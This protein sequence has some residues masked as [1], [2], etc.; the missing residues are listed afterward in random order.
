MAKT[1]TFDEF[2]P[3][4]NGS[5]R[6]TNGAIDCPPHNSY[7]EVEHD[8]PDLAMPKPF[9]EQ[10]GNEIFIAGCFAV[11]LLVCWWT[12]TRRPPLRNNLLIG[13]ATIGAFILNPIAGAIVLAAWI[14]KAK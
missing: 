14:F 8:P 10:H 6:K 7:L 4:Q 12:F 2:I 3:S 13:G 5:C 9:L 11:P 1:L